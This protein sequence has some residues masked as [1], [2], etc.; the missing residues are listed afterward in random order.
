MMKGKKSD[1]G[2]ISFFISEC[3]QA[4]L[5]TPAEI[6]ARAKKQIADIDEEIKAV[7]TAKITRSKLLDVISSFEKPVKDKAEE[8]KLLA[9]FDLK[10]HDICKSICETVKTMNVLR[11]REINVKVARQPWASQRGHHKD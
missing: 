4:G 10:Y 6:V 5:E 8:A 2:F 11:Y 1:P 7:E 3:V 9:F